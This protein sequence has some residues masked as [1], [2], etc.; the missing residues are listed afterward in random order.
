MNPKRTPH[1]APPRRPAAAPAPPPPPGPAPAPPPTRARGS[2][3]CGE[4]GG[5]PSAAN[6]TLSNSSFT[7]GFSAKMHTMLQVPEGFTFRD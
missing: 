3:G 4:R 2:P 6:R 7:G 1:R 5:S